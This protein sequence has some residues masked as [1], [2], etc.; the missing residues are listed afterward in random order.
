MEAPG[1]NFANYF[2]GSESQHSVDNFV[3]DIEASHYVILLQHLRYLN[4]AVYQRSKG[5]TFTGY[6]PCSPIQRCISEIHLTFVVEP[7]PIVIKLDIADEPVQVE[8]RS[9]TQK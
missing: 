5:Q 2:E 4:A 7:F 1:F 9:E 6:F 8:P 3:Y